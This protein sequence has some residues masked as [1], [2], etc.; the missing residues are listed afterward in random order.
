MEFIKRMR[1]RRL[2]NHVEAL[3]DFYS[4]NMEVDAYQLS[5][6]N[7]LWAIYTQSLPS[8]RDAV[9]AGKTPVHFCSFDEYV[10]T[11]QVYQRRHL[12]SELKKFTFASPT[13]T[14]FRTTG[15]STSEPISLPAWKSEF[16]HTAASQWLGRYWQGV[17]PSDRL[18]LLWGHSHLLGAGLRGKLNGLKR[19]ALDYLLGYYR[20]SAYDLSES[21][22]QGAGD[23]LLKFKPDYIYGYS[24]ALDQ[25]A[26][27]NQSRTEAF[28]SLKLKCVQAT[29]ERFPAPESKQL[30]EAVFGCPVVMEYGAMETGHIASTA[31][32]GVGYQVYWKDYFVEGLKQEDGSH[33]I[34]VTSLFPRATPL[35]RYELGDTICLHAN[36]ATKEHVLGIQKFL[37]VGGRCN[38]GIKL[39][40]GTFFHSEVFTHCVRDLKVIEAFQIVQ[41][42][43]RITVFYRAKRD[44]LEEER[45]SAL[46]RFSKVDSRLRNVEFGRVE[47][48]RKSVAGKTPM[49]IIQKA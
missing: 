8:V 30:V 10:R 32:D 41:E 26:R 18:F 49:I 5:A 13:P 3:V 11:V 38:H 27:A 44:L 48:L 24:V 25:F 21:A 40:D 47:E 23:Q 20:A 33:K 36:D 29:A 12:A 14:S 43:D 17:L 34:L 1:S 46:S 22:L 35:I 7:K 42:S 39:A 4:E 28:H 6:L 16:Q 19:Q 2:E 45:Q 31:Q 15:G 37:D 9:R